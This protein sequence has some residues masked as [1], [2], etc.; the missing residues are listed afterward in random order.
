MWSD[1]DKVRCKDRFKALVPRLAGVRLAGP[2][3]EHAADEL[4]ALPDEMPWMRDAVRLVWRDARR[5]AGAGGG[6][7]LRP[8]LLDG[9]PGVGKS[10]F[11][12]R[13]AALAGVPFASIDIGTGSEGFRVAGLTKGWSSAHPGRPVETVLAEGVGNP[14]VF[15]DEIDKGGVMHG[16]S[17]K[18]TSAHAALLGLLEPSTAAAWECP[19]YQVRFDMS[20]VNWIL[21]G[22]AL[23]PIPAPLVSRCRVVGLGRLSV[24]DLAAVARREGA[25]RGIESAALDQLAAAVGRQGAGPTPRHVLRLAR[26]LADREG[27]DPP[28]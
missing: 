10:H 26:D 17:G 20:R 27:A 14:V 8:L 28:H 16:T 21:A 23:A 19:F 25:R 1:R 6:F 4:A 24:A 18:A 2:R 9:P 5:S 11:A 7:G 3:T 13:V 15:V 12:R 22:N